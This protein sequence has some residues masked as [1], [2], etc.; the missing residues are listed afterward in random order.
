MSLPSVPPLL[1]LAIACRVDCH[2]LSNFVSLIGFDFYF[3]SES[4]IEIY[5]E[6]AEKDFFKPETQNLVWRNFPQSALAPLPA[7]DLFFT[8]LS[9]ANNSPVLYYHLKDRQSLSNYF[10][11]NDT[12]QRVHNFY[13][14]REILPQMWVGTAQKELEKTRIDNIRL[15]YYKSFVADK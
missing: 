12:A 15:Y 3:N 14:Y 11:L 2:Y 1:R 10:R 8:G 13:Q 6:V 4:E 5:A 9:K 7:S